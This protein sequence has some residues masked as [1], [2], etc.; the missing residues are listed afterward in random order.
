MIRNGSF[1]DLKIPQVYFITR[2]IGGGRCDRGRS[3]TPPVE[4]RI[5]ARIGADRAVDRV[6]SRRARP[7]GTEIIFRTL[8]L[9]R[10]AERVNIT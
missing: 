3:E 10:E 5:G 1:T 8:Y 4:A 9:P 2:M 6:R 7:I